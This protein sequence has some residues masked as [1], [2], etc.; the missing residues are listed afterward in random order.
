MPGIIKI[1]NRN[2]V[3]ELKGVDKILALKSRL[4]IPLSHIK[5]VSTRKVN[6]RLF[7]KQLKIVGTGLPPFIKAGTF[8]DKKQGWLFYKMN[9]TNKVI[10]VELKN[11]RY[12]KIIFE[13]E[14][15][16]A[17]AKELLA[18]LSH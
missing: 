1:K 13:V 4:I 9:D 11:E 14:D 16:E 15:K 5:S 6:W 3:F 8:W 17:T 2:A 12:K 10:T 7:P 18:Y